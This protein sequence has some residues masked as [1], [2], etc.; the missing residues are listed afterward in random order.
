MDMKAKCISA[1]VLLAA[2]AC[3]SSP[4]AKAPGTNPEDMS[5]AE[6]NKA[7]DQHEQMAAEH[8]DQAASVQPTG[9][10]PLAEEATR[11]DEQQKADK[12]KDIAKQHSDA[13]SKASKP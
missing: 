3:G 11:K 6:H 2:N 7:A 1:F 8:E 9:R 10:T 13:A 12:E 5:A 4:P